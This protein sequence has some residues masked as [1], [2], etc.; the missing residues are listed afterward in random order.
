MQK[1]HEGNWDKAPD[2]LRAA[3]NE[4]TRK[5]K[6]VGEWTGFTERTLQKV[7]PNSSEFT[8]KD[9][10]R[11]NF[12]AKFFLRIHA[13]RDLKKT[14]FKPADIESLK[15]FCAETT[16]LRK[17][18]ATKGHIPGDFSSTVDPNSLYSTREEKFAQLDQRSSYDWHN[19]LPVDFWEKDWK[20]LASEHNRGLKRR[21]SFIEL[22]D[23]TEEPNLATYQEGDAT[24]ILEE[25]RTKAA[26]R[27]LKLRSIM[28]VAMGGKEHEK[29]K[30]F[31]EKFGTRNLSGDN[32][33][34]G[35]NTKTVIELN[36]ALQGYLIEIQK[37]PSKDI[38]SVV[39]S[40]GIE[41]GVPSEG[42]DVKSSG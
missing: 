19:V 28:K 22:S 16:L 3:I 9:S 42:T 38:E 36:F 23:L 5:E 20:T 4:V 35:V 29:L 32:P 12:I 14:N 39:P 40:E 6:G 25:I 2:Y 37:M 8:F 18:F 30:D 15:S 1:W 10:D 11:R 17:I 31:Q 34:W 26:D 24:P 13:F 21:K 41:P 7:F 33:F 27:F